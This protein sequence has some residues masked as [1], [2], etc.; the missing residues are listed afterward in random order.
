MAC[1]SPGLRENRS[2]AVLAVT[3]RQR[4]KPKGPEEDFPLLLQVGGLSTKG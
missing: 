3:P 2:W 1:E 4:Q